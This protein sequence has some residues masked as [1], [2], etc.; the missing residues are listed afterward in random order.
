MLPALIASV[1]CHL[2]VTPGDQHSYI[3][4][5]IPHGQCSTC[6]PVTLDLDIEY[7]FY[8]RKNP[9]N[10]HV[11]QYGNKDALRNSTF[12]PSNPTTIFI[13]G[14]GQQAMGYAAKTILKNY[15]KRGDYNMILVDWKKLAAQHWYNVAA[16]NSKLVGRHVAKFLNWLE[17][18]NGIN[19]KKIHVVGFSLGAEAA[20][21]MGKSLKPKQVGRITG[22]DP[23]YP[24]FMKG[25]HLTA[26]DA[27][28]VDV[29]HTDSKHFGFPSPIGHA[30]FYPNGG[31]SPQPGCS[32]TQIITMNI[33]SSVR[34]YLTCSHHRAWW[35]FS[36]SILNPHGFPAMRCQTWQPNIHNC[37][38]YPDA[39]MGIAINPSARGIY[40]LQTN[41]NAPYA[42][43]LLKYDTNSI[44][45]ML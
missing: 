26:G 18:E 6:C 41:P 21:F 19:M 16:A 28:F 8:T 34:L 22:L 3:I 45:D 39:S 1:V 32:L 4:A 35:Y 33:F 24:L 15:L 25:E 29:I 36:E 38:G 42:K 44:L 20:G 5:P 11:I 13:H 14:Y 2:F 43:N 17:L 37:S 9:E 40:Y 7:H 12:N 30:D 10:P 31:K 23:A 27:L